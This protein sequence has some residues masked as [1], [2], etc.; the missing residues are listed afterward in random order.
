MAKKLRIGFIGAGGIAVGH[1][2]RI[3]E[4][5]KAEVTAL[6]EPSDEMLK[7]FCERCEG[8]DKLPVYR[9]YRDMLKNEALDAVVV[10]SPHTCHYEQIMTSLD[11]GLHVLTEKP[12]VCSIKHAKAVIEKAKAAK[13][14]L[15]IAYQR[16]FDPQFRYMRDQIAKGVLGEIQYVQAIQAQEWL[17]ATKGTWRQK[18]ALSGGGQ[19]NDSGSHLVDIVMWV[20]GMKVQEVFAKSE[21]FGTEVD[22]NST[23]AMR[24]ENG[25]LGS[26]SIIGNA[27]AWYEDH[28]IVGSKGAFY[29]RQG[30][31]L[32]QQDAVGRPVKIK[33]PKYT[34]NHDSNFIDSILGKDVPQTPPECGLRTIEVTEA[35]W[36]SAKTGKSVRVP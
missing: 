16:H 23:L 3:H 36:K 10:L 25:A 11:K 2:R 5:K 27:P 14:I 8:A 18:L 22:I 30:L 35:A 24:F 34:K 32:I 26:M 6:T 9:D 21:N 17:R 12:M 33:L 31:G 19:L 15:M 7:R 4:T 20:T 1:Y 28:S 29:L 13:R